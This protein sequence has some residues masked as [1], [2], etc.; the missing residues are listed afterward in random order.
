ML[1]ITDA[2]LRVFEQH[3]QEEYIGR[4]LEFFR[5]QAAPLF[6]HLS[7]AE[8]RARIRAAIESA[9]TLG[10]ISDSGLVKYAALSM[11]C[12]LE[13]TR[14][15]DVLAFLSTP[16]RSLDVKLEWLINRVATQLNDLRFV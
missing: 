7:D 15:R 2:M 1:K 11:L 8:A 12:G 9:K 14:S 6:D 13:F 10:D 5:S 16:G 3:R 4:L